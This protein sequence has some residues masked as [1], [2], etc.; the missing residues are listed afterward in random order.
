MGGGVSLIQRICIYYMTYIS[1]HPPSPQSLGAS[2]ATHSDL[3][4][5]NAKLGQE[6]DSLAAANERINSRSK[7]AVQT[8]MV[9]GGGGVLKR[10][11]SV[12]IVL[13]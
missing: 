2:A 10:W 11:R 9:R 5:Q 4:T 1:L 13:L 12:E 8:A 7:E 3:S 6:I